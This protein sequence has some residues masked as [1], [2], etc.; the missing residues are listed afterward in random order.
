MDE[1]T[2]LHAAAKSG[3]TATVRMLLEHGASKDA[4][5]SRANT[6]HKLAVMFGKADVAQLLL[7]ESASSDIAGT[8]E[9]PVRDLSGSGAG[10]QALQSSPAAASGGI[11]TDT[12]DL[13]AG[14]G[15]GKVLQPRKWVGAPE[16]KEPEATGH[17]MACGSSTLDSPGDPVDA[18]PP[19]SKYETTPAAQTKDLLDC[20]A[21]GSGEEESSDEDNQGS[22]GVHGALGHSEV[23]ANAGA[24]ACGCEEEEVERRA[25]R[26]LLEELRMRAKVE[27]DHVVEEHFS[28]PGTARS[29]SAS[30]LSSAGE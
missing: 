8:E 22:S 10:R 17:S 25:A 14:G 27:A 12:A 23:G 4:I 26:A 15:R 3:N 30:A 28:R 5:N 13:A 18:S 2:P 6:P 21:H 9:K 7:E 20:E 1:D 19:R 29:H 24:C 16:C 11:S